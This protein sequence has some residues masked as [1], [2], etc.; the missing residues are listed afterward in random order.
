MSFPDGD[1]DGP[2]LP[3][4]VKNVC[5]TRPIRWRHAQ[6]VEIDNSELTL[7]TQAKMR[8]ITSSIPIRWQLTLCAARVWLEQYPCTTSPRQ[9]HG[10]QNF[11]MSGSS[12]GIERPVSAGTLPRGPQDP[13][14]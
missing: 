14:T 5:P 8:Y 12:L 13:P 9:G 6:G 7:S 2:L 10:L 11:A 4:V 3:K 1:V